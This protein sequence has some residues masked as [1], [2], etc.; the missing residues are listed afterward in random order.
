MKEQG[1]AIKGIYGF[2]TGWC[3][4]RKEAIEYHCKAL[5]YTW[6]QCKKKGDSAVKII[7]Q[8]VNR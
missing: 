4:T 5:G 1:W 6:E 3:I 7:I 2:Y 8:E